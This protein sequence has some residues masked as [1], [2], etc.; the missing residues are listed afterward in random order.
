MGAHHWTPALVLTLLPSLVAAQSIADGKELLKWE[1][2][3]G[4]ETEAYFGSLDTTENTVTLLRPITLPLYKLSDDSQEVAYEMAAK[5]APV[6]RNTDAGP[7]A[8]TE[9]TAKGDGNTGIFLLPVD[10]G[11]PTY[12]EWLTWPRQKQY[13][14]CLGLLIELHARGGLRFQ[15]K[16]D[17]ADP[18]QVNDATQKLWVAVTGRGMLLSTDS[19][20]PVAPEDLRVSEVLAD[21]DRESLFL[22]PL[23]TPDDAQ[24]LR[25]Q[26]IGGAVYSLLRHGFR[27]NGSQFP[28]ELLTRATVGLGNLESPP[29]QNPSV[30]FRLSELPSTPEETTYGGWNFM[31]EQREGRPTA[32]TLADMITTLALLFP[33]YEKKSV[34]TEILG[35]LVQRLNAGEAKS[36]GEQIEVPKAKVGPKLYMRAVVT[37]LIVDEGDPATYRSELLFA[38]GPFID[39]SGSMAEHMRDAVERRFLFNN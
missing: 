29:G 35:P 34:V 20:N 1:S 14:Y 10:A 26:W 37:N 13:A 15:W 2:H 39:Y 19:D 4:T 21:Y 32:K 6:P 16:P 5:A 38:Q 12:A 27:P 28:T 8:Q 36:P 22:K 25:Q 7:D 11:D 17:L 9:S 33:E 18:M 31:T 23:P 3:T 24:L 30:Q